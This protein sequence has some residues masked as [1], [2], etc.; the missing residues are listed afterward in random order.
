LILRLIVERL[1]PNFRA[2]A[3]LLELAFSSAW[4][5]S[6]SAGNTFEWWLSNCAAPYKAR[7]LGVVALEI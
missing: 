5:D 3:V 4:V 6:R 7:R 2:I 1:M